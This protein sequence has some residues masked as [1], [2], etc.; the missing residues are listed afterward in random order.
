MDLTGKLVTAQPDYTTALVAG[1]GMVIATIIAAVFATVRFSKGD[2]V[3]TFITGAILTV[4]VAAFIA[5]D[6]DDARSD[7]AAAKNAVT[8]KKAAADD[9]L[10]LS[11]GDAKR[12][13]RERTRSAEGRSKPLAVLA[14]QDGKAGPFL[15]SWVSKN[16]LLV[17]PVNADNAAALKLIKAGE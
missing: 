4:A 17:V 9:G 2:G 14:E 10:T 12:I 3:G 16:R 13:V 7:D 11:T 15:L 5:M 8:V 6:E 1:L